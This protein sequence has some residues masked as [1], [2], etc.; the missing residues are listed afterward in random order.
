MVRMITVLL[1]L[2]S[3]GASAQDYGFSIPR[4]QCT[5]TVN[6]DRSLTIEYDIEFVC[7][8]GNHSIDIVDIGFPTEDYE[9]ESVEASVD[10]VPVY[11]IIR[12]TY[13]DVGVEVHLAGST[14]Y[15]GENGIFRLT[16]TNPD[17]VFRD[18]EEDDYASVE[19]TPT[20]FDGDF[21]HGS[22]EF[23]LV[24]I[25]PT[26]AVAD[27]VRFHEVPFTASQSDSKGRVAYTWETRRRVSEPFRVGISFPSHLVD[28]P[29]TDRPA[30]PL[31]SPQALA[32]LI[33]IGVI[34]IISGLFVWIV[35][36]SVRKAKKRRISYLPPS[37]GVEGSEIRRGLTAPFAALLLEEKL[38]RVLILI[39]FGLL[40]KGALQLTGSGDE[41]E[42]IKTG[43]IT[44][45]RNYEKAFI[46]I[47]PGPED[48]SKPPESEARKIFVDMIEELEEK[49]E[50]FSLKE[51][52]E[53]YRSIIRNAWKMVREAGSPDKA[54]SILAERFGW[55][56]ADTKFDSMVRD[57]PSFTSTAYPIWFRGLVLHT[58]SLSGGAN[59]AE[60]CSSL[61]GTLE[62]AAGRAVSSITKLSS[63]VTSVTNP[64]P[65]S[66][67]YGGSS[68]GSSCACACAC[69]GCACACAGG[70]R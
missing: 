41:A 8:S 9:L 30:P 21:L 39:L 67:S 47:L 32:L 57:L 62:G 18:T 1:L 27:S 23:E 3:I 36:A 14:I 7:G 22:S 51:T 54:A 44:G 15:P 55:L 11:G 49:M 25:F 5:V 40:R 38:D 19:F 63:V 65:V 10:G 42:V 17:M 34:S 43:S 20:W 48:S 16:G 56:F 59:I 12:S 37:I 24:M 2:L 66:R 50:G 58:N 45:L 52:R 70:G 53:Y 60:I 13:I 69:A 64:V 31:L 33:T 61:A 6:Q 46:S 29:L 26:G 4:F 28:G 35:V 68:S